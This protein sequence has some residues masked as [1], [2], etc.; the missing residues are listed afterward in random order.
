VSIWLHP[1]KTGG[2]LT[3]GN[4]PYKYV[5]GGMA[6]IQESP[7]NPQDNTIPVI[8]VNLDLADTQLV[9]G[10]TIKASVCLQCSY[11]GLPRE[12][13]GE[14]L[15]GLGG[16]AKCDFGRDGFLVCARGKLGKNVVLS[17][18]LKKGEFKLDLETLTRHSLKKVIQLSIRQ[19]SG[20]NLLLGEVLLRKYF[21]A[22]DYT[23]STVKFGPVRHKFG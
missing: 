14:L 1:D 11:L 6:H 13:A 22:L 10:E 20:P 4:I 23:T 19:T 2:T 15:A 8:T 9:L 18:M 7:F 3:L 12:V 5:D 21:L 16:K 17:I